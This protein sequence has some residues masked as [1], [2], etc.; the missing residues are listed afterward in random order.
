MSQSIGVRIAGSGRAL[1]QR[2]LTNADLERLMDTSDEWIVQRTG[3]RSR[4]VAD[5]AHGETTSV[6]AEQAVV[7]ALRNAGISGEQVDLVIAATMTSEMPTPSVSARVAHAIGTNYAGAFD[8]NAACCGFVFGLNTAHA[9][10]R[11]GGYKTIVL[12]GADTITQHCSYCTRGRNTAVL[13]GDGAGAIVL[14]R[15]P[16][17]SKGLIAQA[18]HADGGGWPDLYVPVREEQLPAG[19]DRDDVM[20][21]VIAMNGRAVFKFAVGRF[22][23]LIQQTLDKAGL[24]PGDVD[25][26]V[27]HQSN[28]RILQAA[29][30]RFGLPEEK[31]YVNIDRFGNTVGASVPL[32][33]DELREAGRIKPGQRVMF[34]GFGAGLTWGSSLW[35]M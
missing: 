33:F 23:D 12:I 8:L 17:P 31:L 29:R 26:Y 19:G 9:L 30:E 28:A 35:Q 10:I 15:D 27:C 14:T 34:V 24:E 1:P 16:D 20:V 22:P 13:F 11:D 5:M 6:L 7:A 25:V 18:M 21:N 32:C 4:H 3:I 2:R